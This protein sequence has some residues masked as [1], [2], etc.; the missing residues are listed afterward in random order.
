MGDAS[1]D[2]E[3]IERERGALGNEQGWVQRQRH[4]K[5]NAVQCQTP[6]RSL[7]VTSVTKLQTKRPR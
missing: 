5:G 4:S 7:Q 2:D 1:G 6:K 3:A